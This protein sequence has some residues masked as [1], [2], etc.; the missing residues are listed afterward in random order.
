MKALEGGV[1]SLDKS[2]RTLA[3]QLAQLTTAT[4]PASVQQLADSTGDTLVRQARSL[5]LLATACAAAVVLLHA[6]LRPWGN[7]P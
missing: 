6:L 4:Q 3:G 7:R 1:A 2:V 5:M